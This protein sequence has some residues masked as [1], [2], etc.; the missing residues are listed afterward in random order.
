MYLLMTGSEPVCHHL[1]LCLVVF[2][3]KVQTLSLQVGSEGACFVL[4]RVPALGTNFK[5]GPISSNSSNSSSKCMLLLRS[6]SYA[7]GQW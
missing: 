1:A 4:V 7:A 3:P 6:S 5:Q 2:L